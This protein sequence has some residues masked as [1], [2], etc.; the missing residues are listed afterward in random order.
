[1]IRN[2]L[3]LLMIL[4][5]L[6]VMDYP[7]ITNII[8]EILGV[9]T[10]LL[11]MIHNT[12]N[13]HWYT[14]IGKGK[15]DL[16]RIIKTSM[17]LLFLIIIILVAV[18]GVLIS[19]TIFSSFSLS[20]NLWAHELHILSAFWGFILLSIHIGFHGKALWGKLCH[21]LRVDSTTLSYILL[22]RAASLL[23]IIYGIYAS[24]KRN[25]GSKLLLQHVFNEY[26]AQPS[27]VSFIVDYAAIMGCYVVI[28]YYLTSLFQKIR[29]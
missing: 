27:L 6:V 10:L 8:H 25:I 29:S 21:W 14:A 26:T 12:L 15:M 23:I 16:L 13:R 4:C 11:F 5:I 2:T 18:T 24:S 1:M 20:D 7:F 17:N 9:F 19:Q 3:N 22:S 28:T